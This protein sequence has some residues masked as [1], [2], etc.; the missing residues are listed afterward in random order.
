MRDFLKTGLDVNIGG[1]QLT[2]AWHGAA[3]IGNVEAMTLLLEHPNIRLDVPDFSGRTPL[4]SVASA[5]S[6][7]IVK[8]LLD[9]GLVKTHVR[10]TIGRYLLWGLPVEALWRSSE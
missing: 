3:T 10:T 5:G 4:W 1:G 2:S 6:L 8:Q 9:T 7:E